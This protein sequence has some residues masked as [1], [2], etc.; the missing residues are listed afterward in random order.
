MKKT[1]VISISLLISAVVLAQ[2]PSFIVTK[3]GKGDAVLFLPGFSTPGTVWDE[4][5]RNLK[6]R[7]ETHVFTYAGFGNVKPIDTPW[8]PSIR[9]DLIAYINSNKLS[10]ITIIGH[11]MGGTLAMDIGA[12]LPG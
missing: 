1:F 9:R 7:N 10:G 3:A 12:A 2:S 11:S 5:L 6:G 4:T 8:Y